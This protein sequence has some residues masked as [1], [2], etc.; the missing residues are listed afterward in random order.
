MSQWEITGEFFESCNCQAICP[1]VTLSPPTQGECKAL[2]GWSITSGKSGDHD[3]SGRKV[4]LAVHTPGPMTEGNWRVALYIDDGASGAQMDELTGIFAG[5]KGGHFEILGSFIGEVAGV[6]QVP[7][8]IVV[9]G[10]SRTLRVPDIAE[11]SVTAIEGHDGKDVTV[12]D[13]PLAVVPGG[14]QTVARSNGLTYRD[15]DFDWV[16]ADGSSSLMAPFTYQG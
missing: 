12:T 6:K 15:F 8:E 2:V 4:M 11:T 5:Q 10:K 7:L 14:A 3:L 9:D 1:C 13:T 16:H